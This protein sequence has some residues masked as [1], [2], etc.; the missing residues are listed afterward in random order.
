[1]G[2]FVWDCT[3]PSHSFVDEPQKI[4]F[5]TFIHFFV[6]VVDKH[7]LALGNINITLVSI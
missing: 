2:S 6:V 3:K 7:S 4:S 5:F 1:M